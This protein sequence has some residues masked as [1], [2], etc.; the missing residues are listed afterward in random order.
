MLKYLNI[1]ALIFVLLA[2]FIIQTTQSVYYGSSHVSASQKKNASRAA[3]TG[4]WYKGT[5]HTHTY[6]P[7]GDSS[8]ESV[9]RWY[10]THRYNFLVI[11]DHN[12]LVE[13]PAA[14]ALA[15]DSFI[16]I[17]G[18][19]ITQYL[20]KRPVHVN[21][22]NIKREV[23]P[24][25][26]KTVEEMLMKDIDAIRAAG[27]IP[28]INHPN[29]RWGFND[30]EIIRLK[31][32]KSGP[33]L[34]EIY[35]CNKDCNNYGGGGHKSMEEI[36]DSL[37]SQGMVIYGVASDDAHHF[38]KEFD[39]ERA[40]PG[41]GWVMVKA[42]SLSAAEITNAMAQG[43]FYGTTGITLDDVT[44]NDRE[45]TVSMKHEKKLGYSTHFIGKGWRTLKVDTNDRAVYTFSG[46]ELY[47][48]ARVLC[49][50]GDIA[51]TQPHFLPRGGAGKVEGK[52]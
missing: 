35:N 39:P 52:K 2:T 18:E 3:G 25:T 47:V 12:R 1:A 40:N 9:S 37:L 28:Q 14:L 17:P 15:D 46:D 29:W 16:L 48:R 51:I 19:E 22:I 30:K 42:P 11:S 4:K 32:Q 6:L 33:Y 26:G 49:S 21:G 27:G 50:S 5:T 34:M 36:W 44:V 45:Y 31:G 24:Q 13:D 38:K 23:E 20:C 43:H 7:D 10:K 8:P 41:R